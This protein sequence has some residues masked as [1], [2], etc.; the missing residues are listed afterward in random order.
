[1]SWPSRKTAIAM[2]ALLAAAVGCQQ[3]PTV[4]KKSP[5]KPPQMLRDSCVLEMFFVRFP[6]GDVEANQTLWQEIDELQSAPELRQRLLRNGF[7]V[8]LLSGQ[9]PSSLAHLMELT[10]KPPVAQQ[11]EQIKLTDLADKPRVTRG[12]MHA[13][14]GQRHEIVTSGVY[15][16]L[17]V[18]VW[19]GNQVGGRTYEQAQ[20]VLALKAFPQTDGRVQIE[21]IPELQYGQPKRSWVPDQG[22]WRSDFG[23]PKR[24][25]EDL[26]L[27]ATLAPGSILVVASLPDCPGSLGHYFFTEKD[28]RP[29]QKM[30]LIR[31]V[32]TPQDD[33]FAPSDVLPLE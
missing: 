27:T 16:Q 32:Q 30:L 2:L 8:G 24:T 4:R 19:E 3:V 7:R 14:P 23:R 22:V 10:T 9:I 18:L 31:L 13:R 25:F 5:F 1:M 33:L 26:A 20:G 15:E 17:P 21:L 6:F 29:E 12:R 11:D 28:I